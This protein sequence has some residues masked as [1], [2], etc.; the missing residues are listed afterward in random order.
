MGN[1]TLFELGCHGFVTIRDGLNRQA[2]ISMACIYLLY[3][4]YYTLVMFHN[5]D[6]QYTVKN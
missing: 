6:K 3:S 5:I 2:M 1:T 4:Y